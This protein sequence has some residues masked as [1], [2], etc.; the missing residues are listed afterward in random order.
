MQRRRLP[1]RADPVTCEQLY[2]EADQAL[3]QA[4][5]R[6]KGQFCLNRLP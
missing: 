4:K 5:E 3:Y 1:N 6:G 2:S